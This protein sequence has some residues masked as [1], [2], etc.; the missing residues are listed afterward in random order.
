MISGEQ[1]PVPQQSA[2][3]VFHL[4]LAYPLQHDTACFFW[5]FSA[6]CHFLTAG[7]MA[8]I[9][10][11]ADNMTHNFQKFEPAPRRGEPE[12]ASGGGTRPDYFLVRHAAQ[13]LLHS[14]WH[15]KQ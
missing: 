9:M 11:V 4:S 8:G 2:A 1:L 5:I 12:A 7:N 10:E 13:L 3:Q 6:I 15:G 14:V